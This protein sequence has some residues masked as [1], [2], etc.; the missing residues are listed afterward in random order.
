MRLQDLRSDFALEQ[1]AL[2]AS[3]VQASPH[4]PA[5]FKHPCLVIAASSA[6]S[7]NMLEYP[8]EYVALRGETS[9]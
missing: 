1:E 7:M 8:K 5:I 6:A 3:R 4:F 2:S 9:L